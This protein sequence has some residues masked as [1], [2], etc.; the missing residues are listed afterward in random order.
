MAATLLLWGVETVATATLLL[1][2]VE[3]V[4]VTLLPWGVE[5]VA[6]TL[7]VSRAHASHAKPP[8]P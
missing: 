7:L 1:W 3:A 8:R 6:A 4:A 5:T 2:G